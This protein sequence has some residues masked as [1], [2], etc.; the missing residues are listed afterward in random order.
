[1]ML[2]GARRLGQS[3]CCLEEVFFVAPL[4]LV[5]KAERTLQAV[6]DPE[7]GFRIISMAAEDAASSADDMITHVR[8]R[9]GAAGERETPASLLES[10]QARCSSPVDKAAFRAAIEGIEFGPSFQW[11]ESLSSGPGEELARLR[12]PQ[13]VGNVDG[14]WLHPGLLDA[15]L[16]AAGAT[17]PP[18]SAS[19]VILPFGVKRLEVSRPA[20]GVSWWCHVRQVGEFIWN[21]HLFDDAGAVIALIQGFEMRKASGE[22]FQSRRMA[23]WIYLLEWQP[24]PLPE[25]R[26]ARRQPAVGPTQRWLIVDNAEGIGREMAERWQ[27]QER[28]TLAVTE[29]EIHKALAET[30]EGVL[31]L[32]GGASNG[33]LP[34]EAELSCIRLLRLAQEMSLAGISP[35]LWLVTVGSQAVTGADAVVLA[36]APIW[37]LARTLQLE[38]PALRC[39][40]VDLPEQPTSEDVE[41]LLSEL[42]APSAETQV[43]YRSG[44]RFVARLVRHREGHSPK[45]EG[46]VRLQLAKYGSPD[47]LRLVPMTRRNPGPGEVEIEVK[48]AALNFRDVLIALGLLKDY[49]AQVLKIDRAQDVRLGFDCAGVIAAVGEGVTDFQ[50]GDEVMTSAPGSFTSFFTL[51]RTDVVHKPAGLSFESAAGIPTA[52]FT[53]HYGLCQLAGLKPGE[54]VL[55]HAAAGGVG[56][57]AVQVARAVGAEVFATASPGKWEFLKRQGIAH[58]LNSRTL[59][60]ADEIM[61]LTEGAGVDVVLNSLT[62]ETIGKSFD[63]LR[64]GGRFVEIGKLGIWSAEQVA[65]RRPDV[66]Y[67]TFDLD[68]SIDQDAGLPHRTLGEVRAWFEAGRLRPLPQRVFPVQEAVEAYRFLQQVRQVGKVV[69]SFAPLT[70]PSPPAAGEEGRVRGEGP[71]LRGDGAYLITGGLGGLGLKTAEH[72]VELGARQLVLVGRSEPCTAAQETIERLRSAGASVQV[73]QADVARSAEVGRLVESCRPALRGIVHAAGVLDDGVLEKQTAERFELEG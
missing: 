9:L 7:G 16:Q 33:D 65:Q 54:R 8:G 39:V 1:M 34:T 15:C 27:G 40:C 71:A 47:Q 51:P 68:Q 24:L 23:D 29:D 63:A 5:D 58:V 73:V 48:A 69:L 62:G 31:Y 52:F 21:I 66:S 19:E 43:A 6:L 38:V 10:A 44:E 26:A 17:L 72:L 56:Q 3:S 25:R 55:I 13:A 4:V 12:L 37:G 42:Q 36:A 11:I 50:V 46:P 22:D 57:A 35:R 14:Y 28:V 49:Y 64:Q 41:L 53:S 60:F 20:A 2:N 32:S 70:L 45:P 61:R 30:P 18:E 67:F 59:A